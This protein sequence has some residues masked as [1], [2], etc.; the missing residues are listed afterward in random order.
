MVTITLKQAAM[1][2]GVTSSTIRRWADSGKLKTLRTAGGHRR[3]SHE[4]VKRLRKQGLSAHALATCN[5][6]E[7]FEPIRPYKPGDDPE[8]D[9]QLKEANEASFDLDQ[10]MKRTP[11]D[12]DA[13]HNDS[14]DTSDSSNTSDSADTVDDDPLGL[15]DL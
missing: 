14:S 5:P 8:I 9:R 4:D 7:P 2:L 11:A 12:L 15:N 10:M 1:I 6:I 13:F 3:V